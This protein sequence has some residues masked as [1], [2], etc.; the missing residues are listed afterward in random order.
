[1]AEAG[2]KADVARAGVGRKAPCLGA[3]PCYSIILLAPIQCP[4]RSGN[5][6]IGLFFYQCRKLS[7]TR[8]VIVILQHHPCLDTENDLFENKHHYFGYT[9][10]KP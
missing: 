1:M 10:F 5:L 6:L 7:L 8:L 4:V 9:L 3:S 2:R